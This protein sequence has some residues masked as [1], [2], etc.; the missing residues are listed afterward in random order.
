MGEQDFQLSQ[1]RGEAVDVCSITKCLT[2]KK[3]EAGETDLFIQISPPTLHQ[4]E[5]GNWFLKPK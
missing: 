1:K 2:N 5:L 3:Y 4:L